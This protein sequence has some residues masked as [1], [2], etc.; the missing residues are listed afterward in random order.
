MKMIIFIIISMIF[1]M[2]LFVFSIC[3]IE[4]L[5][6]IDNNAP[7]I[8]FNAFKKIYVLSPSKWNFNLDSVT[9]KRNEGW[10]HVEFKHYID[11]LKYNY[12][13]NKIEKDKLNL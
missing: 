5:T 1:S 10:I 12:F 3:S 7:R 11:V 2:I 13:K 6:T 4:W 8:T 9:Y